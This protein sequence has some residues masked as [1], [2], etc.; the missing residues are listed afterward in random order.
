MG[1]MTFETFSNEKG[2]YETIQ[3]FRDLAFHGKYN[4]DL[5]F[6]KQ[7]KYNPQITKFTVGCS[8]VIERWTLLALDARSIRCL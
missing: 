4:Y 7:S 1:K 8:L 5:V 2:K 3:N 6:I